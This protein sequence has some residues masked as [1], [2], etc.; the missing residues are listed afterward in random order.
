MAGKRDEADFQ[1]R[2]DQ[3]LDKAA[4]LYAERGCEDVSLRQVA[5]VLGRT[6]R[7]LCCMFQGKQDLMRSL[8]ERHLDRLM[9]ATG[10]VEQWV[11][12]PRQ[13]LEA[14]A[15]GYAEQAGR[16]RHAHLVFRRDSCRLTE[17]NRSAVEYK[18][19]WLEHAMRNAVM[20]AV[21]VVCVDEEG[22]MVLTRAM[23]GAID[24]QPKVAYEDTRREA[25]LAG[26]AVAMICGPEASQALV[27]AAP[28]RAKWNE[29]YVW[30]DLSHTAEPP[31]W[32]SRYGD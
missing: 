14:M 5:W 3:V 6:E 30:E 25:E 11:G 4:E 7:I 17:L 23:L 26:L 1:R 22:A 29:D 27:G 10:V 32:E 19:R 18:L 31:E 12:T 24:A 21:P 20:R 8:M 13:R 9:A 2:R 16:T 28:K 15:A